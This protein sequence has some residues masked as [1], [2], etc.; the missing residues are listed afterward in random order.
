VIILVVASIV[1]IAGLLY[2]PAT[3][4]GVTDKALAYSVRGEADANET[5]AC[6]SRAGDDDDA[7]LCTVPGA[8]QPAGGAYSVTSD[9][10]GCWDAEPVAK[11]DGASGSLSGCI[12]VVDLI[13]L[14]D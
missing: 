4:I 2:R 12:T 14:D 13:R 6:R 7:Y 11:G 1:A 8:G 5:G 10:Y 3:V 9:T